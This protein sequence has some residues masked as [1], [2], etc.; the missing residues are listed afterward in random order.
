[1]ISTVCVFVAHR[2][3]CESG[4]RK[5]TEC[6]TCLNADRA[7]PVNYVEFKLRTITTVYWQ[8]DR[9]SVII[10]KGRLFVGKKDDVNE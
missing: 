9:P 2:F 5:F 3:L 10:L 1:M 7:Q 6:A 4:Q 8:V